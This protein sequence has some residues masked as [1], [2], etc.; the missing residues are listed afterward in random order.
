MKD[1]L[2]PLQE[3][4]FPE[5]E[6]LFQIEKQVSVIYQERFEFDFASSS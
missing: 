1:L 6:E 2:V 4:G 3:A 5:Q